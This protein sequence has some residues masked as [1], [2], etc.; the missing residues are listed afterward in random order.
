[1]TRN[2]NLP[3]T[4]TT[5]YILLALTQ[6]LHG[7]AAIQEIERLSQGTVK[8][9]AGTMYGAI[10]NLLKLKWIKEVPSSD[11]RRRVYHIT[12]TGQSILRLETQ[13]LRDLGK[14]AEQFGY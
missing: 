9:A 3:L 7:Y 2:K 6:P 14:L 5:Y 10:E 13:R 11:K 4:E 8:V 1:M 12:E